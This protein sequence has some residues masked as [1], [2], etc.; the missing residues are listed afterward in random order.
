[1]EG[2]IEE[3]E[4]EPAGVR[5]ET[6]ENGGVVADEFVEVEDLRVEGLAAAE[7]EELLGEGGALATDSRPLPTRPPP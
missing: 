3:I 1:M 2:L 5:D 6:A 4:H 7:D